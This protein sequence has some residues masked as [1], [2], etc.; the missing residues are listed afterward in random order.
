MDENRTGTI[1]FKW[2]I[3]SYVHNFIQI[4]IIIYIYKYKAKK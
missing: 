2:E 1:H 3:G 4:I